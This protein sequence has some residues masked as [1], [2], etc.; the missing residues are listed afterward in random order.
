MAKP[1]IIPEDETAFAVV[2]DLAEHP[3]ISDRLYRLLM[4][5]LAPFEDCWYYSDFEAPLLREDYENWATMFVPAVTVR[6]LNGLVREGVAAGLLT[7]TRAGGYVTLKRGP[8]LDAYARA[9]AR[10]LSAA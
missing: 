8:I 4:Q 5:W 3:G 7:V 1:K 2:P 9:Y 6:T 10:R